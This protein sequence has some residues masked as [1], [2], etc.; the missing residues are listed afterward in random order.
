[1]AKKATVK[2]PKVE[3]VV[4]TF[5]KYRNGEVSTEHNRPVN[6]FEYVTYQDENEDIHTVYVDLTLC[7]KDI[8][9]SIAGL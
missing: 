6:G 5:E 1:M 7:P 8:K 4:S 2:E 3:K 9:E